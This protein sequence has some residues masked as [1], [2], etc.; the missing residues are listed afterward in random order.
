[1]SKVACFL[2]SCTL[3]LRGTEILEYLI[4]Y[5]KDS[6]FIDIA[7]YIFVNNVGK[8]INPAMFADVSPKIRITNY[9]ADA[10]IFEICTLRQMHFFSQLHPE[11][12]ILYLHTKGVS[13][14]PDHW[15]AP[16]VR[17]WNDFMLYC[18]VNHAQDCLKMLDSVQVVGCDYRH[19]NYSPER[20]PNHFSGNFWW[21]TAQYIVWQSIYELVQKADAEWWLFKGN[22]TFVNIHTCPY[23]HYENRY[24]PHQYVFEV[25]TNIQAHLKNLAHPQDVVVQYGTAGEYLDVT[26]ICRTLV[27]DG[28]LRLPADD[29]ARNRLF[30]DPAPGVR[31]HLLIGSI[32][33]EYESDYT[34]PYGG[35]DSRTSSA[36]ALPYGNAATES[37]DVA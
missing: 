20:N 25:D 21:A 35:S 6:G 16:G 17:D 22:P 31:K 9:C 10:G 14:A 33:V 2:H 29:H 36:A 34:L 32:V 23:G 5:L 30:T 24:L 1:M 4:K 15:A 18:L 37:V 13:H 3:D 8:R 7:D 12:K 28:V 11:Y 26:D 19:I 27:V